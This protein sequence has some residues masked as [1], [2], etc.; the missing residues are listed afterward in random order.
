MHAGR[1]HHKTPVSLVVGLNHKGSGRSWAHPLL[2]SLVLAVL[3]WMPNA[4]AQTLIAVDDTFSV[5]YGQDLVAEAPGVL[6]NDTFDGQPAEDA[7]A[8]ASLVSDVSHGFLALASDGSFTYT[9]DTGFQGSDTFTYE[10]AVG[11][12][13]SQATVTLTACSSGP[14]VFVCWHEAPYLAKLAELGYQSFQE[15]FE[16]D[17]AWGSARAPNTA[18]FVISQGIKWE[19]NHPDPPA[20]N[21]I[22][23][24]AGPARTGL[25]GVY[26]PN[27]GYVSVTT[28]CDVDVPPAGCL[29]KDGFTGTREAGQSTLYGVGGHFTG[30]AGPNLVMILNGGAP[31][32][33]GLVAV[34]DPQFFGVIDTAGFTSFRVEEI[35]GKWGQARLVFA[36]DF[37][38]AHNDPFSIFG[39][40][41]ESGGTLAWSVT[42]P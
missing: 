21:E 19:T 22:T 11:A 14:M 3:G 24:G 7:G 38:L 37:T 5:P 12:N 40:G 33:L 34:G 16:N 18:P 17:V 13:T 35:D 29:F 31:I 6:A 2:V 4:S 36:D 39:D 10:A 28:G 42:I 30:S 9:P 25:W 1:V 27:H 32:G 15:G 20:S 26:D 8:T 23:T 41:F